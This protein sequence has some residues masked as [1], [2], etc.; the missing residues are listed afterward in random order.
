M[1][2]NPK[3][4][5]VAGLD[6]IE[7]PGDTDS[8]V[9]MLLHGFGADAQDL[10]PLHEVFNLQPKPTWIF[11]NGPLE[12]PIMPGYNGRAW[13]P[14][15][16][17]GL[18][19]A[20][21]EGKN[22]AVSNAFPPELTGARERIERLVGE[23]NIPRSKLILGGFSQGAV[24]AVETALNGMDRMAGLLIFSGTLI[25]ESS[26]RRLSSLHAKTPFFQSHGTQDPLL[27]L[28]KAKDLEQLLLEGGLEGKLHI[29]KGGHEIP[30]STLQQLSGFLQVLLS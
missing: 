14:V 1:K 22:E 21:Q 3:N 24:L 25:C 8:P 7:V 6:L 10:F 5:T 19:R 18:Q 20:L 17:E 4:R 2:T 9:I 29:F 13:F 27:P 23:L 26:W 11:P 15:D 28:K 30:H 16:I 12:I